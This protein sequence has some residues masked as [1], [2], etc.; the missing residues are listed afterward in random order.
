MH[1]HLQDL[2]IWEESGQLFTT[3][4]LPSSTAEISSSASR[5]QTRRDSFREL[6]NI[7]SRRSTGAASFLTRELMRTAMLW[8]PLQ[9]V[10]RTL[11]TDRARES[12][13]IVSMQ[14]SS[15][16]TDLHTMR[17]TQPKNSERSAPRWRLL[18]RHSY[19]V[20]Q[21]AWVFATRFQCRRQ[22]G[23]H[24]SKSAQTGPSVSRCLRTGS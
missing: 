2:S 1:L 9:S 19:M 16:L 4:S 23:R 8:R 15:W 5:T 12:L 22:S 7:S 13:S 10:I 24:F 3:I 20:R 17:S 6:R 14:S 11:H 21:H 18:D